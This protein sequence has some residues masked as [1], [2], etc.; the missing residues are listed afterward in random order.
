MSFKSPQVTVLMPVFNGEKYLEEAIGSI[1]KQSFVDFELLIINDGSTDGSAAIINSYHDPRVRPVHNEKNLKLAAALNRGIALARGE[2][3]ARMDCDD[4]SLPE[5]LSRQVSFLDENPS[6][7]L[8]ATNAVAV[9][10]AGENL[11]NLFPEETAVPLEW[12]LI[13]ENPIAHPTVMLRKKFLLE[14]DL[15]YQDIPSEDYDLWCRLVL[16]AKIS[17][18]SEVLL[19]YRYHPDSSYNVEKKR[20]LLQA[21]ASSRD[22]AFAVTRQEIPVFH[23]DLT[24][25]PK[26]M[27]EPP[28]VY[29]TGSVNEWLALLLA[30]SREKFGWDDRG[31][32][33]AK[34]DSRRLLARIMPAANA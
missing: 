7:G 29:D 10:T 21:I 17:R 3:I 14:F 4:L 31:Y 6:C 30:K 12:T 27:G 13:W 8:C 34:D 2:Y 18:M 25:F 5:R 28:K 15:K 1:L 19:H 22:L 23:A 24:I 32:Q 11:F 20:H 9:N 16:R 26:A 33:N